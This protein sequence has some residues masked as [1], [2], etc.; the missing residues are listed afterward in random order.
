V[1][2]DSFE[3]PGIKWGEPRGRGSFRIERH[4]KSPEAHAGTSSE[5][6]MITSADDSPILIAYR[7]DGARVIDELNVGL[8]LKANRPGMQ[9]LAE[10]VLPRSR[11]REGNPL[12]ML[13]TGDFYTQPGNW[14]Q[15]QLNGIRQQI[16]RESRSLRFTF[17]PNVDLREAYVDR[18]ILNVG[19]RGLTT[20]FI[21]DLEL[22]GVA[23]LGAIAS[24]AF[25]PVSTGN[26]NPNAPGVPEQRVPHVRL[27]GTTLLVGDAPM[28]VRAICYRGEPL[29]FLKNLG[30]NTIKLPSPIT[31]DL[32]EQVERLNLWVVC[33]PPA[34]DEARSS[35]VSLPVIGRE[36]DRVLAWDLGDQLASGELE[37]TR[38]NSES[39]RL[40]DREMA[41]PTICSAL[42]ELTRYS[43]HADILVLDRSPIGT[44]LE[45]P[46]YMQWI[47]DRARLARPTTPIWATVQTEPLVELDDQLSRLSSGRVRELSIQA[48]QIRLLAYSAIAGG[49]RGLIFQ[50]RSRLDQSTP[51]AQHR[52]RSLELLNLELS[53]AEPWA[54]SSNFMATIPGSDPETLTAVFETSQSR[55]LLPL[56]SG[57]GTQ[58]VP[59]QL[60]GTNVAFVIPGVPE[61]FN[62]YEITP[63]DLPVPRTRRVAG[64]TRVLMDEF[65]LTGIVLLT[66]DAAA[67]QHVHSRLIAISQRAAM[68]QREL[69]AARL[70]LVTYVDRQLGQQGQIFP[71]SADYLS[72]AQSQFATCDSLLAAGQWQAAYLAAERALR[73]L[74]LIEHGHWQSLRKDLPSLG[75]APFL[76]SVATMPEHRNMVESTTRVRFAPS[77]LVGGDFEQKAVLEQT[78]WRHIYDHEPGVKTGAELSTVEPRFGRFSLRI[79]AQPVDAQ[80]P[81]S[82]LEKVPVWVSSPPVNVAAGELLQIRG[83]IKVPGELGGSVDG[84]MVFDSIG[85]MAMAERITKTNDWQP[86]TFYRVAPQS[87]PVTVHFALTGLGQAWLDEVA[88]ERATFARQSAASTALLPTG[89]PGA[90]RPSL[91]FATRPPTLSN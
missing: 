24:P 18:V 26:P 45:L 85:G 17:G 9:I 60:A 7:I 56:W 90:V 74:R 62:A 67:V 78:G 27:S 80:T 54:G 6:L 77:E 70:Q 12:T 31:P 32:A 65:S 11:D 72:I 10:V 41:R 50:S 3:A 22:T 33:P 25:R 76:T 53:I 81:P 71:K 14:Q 42:T 86:F 30:F 52:A 82:V 83:W 59:G 37:R 75:A 55:V 13:V 29:E 63:A 2:R 51:A 66:G 48:E 49:A 15:L 84:L 88:I 47:R 38:A 64:G 16:D 46:Q 34:G 5:G 20:L 57:K 44:S 89:G 73:P 35:D 21:D 58:Y 43:R 28:L 69:A 19:G 68:L 87:G 91:P 4:E 79:W 61:S 40:R 36:F 1:L 39:I 23:E 8:W